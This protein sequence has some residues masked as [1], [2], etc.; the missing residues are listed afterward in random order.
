MKSTAFTGVLSALSL[1]AKAI[2][3]ARGD[4]LSDYDHAGST[5]CSDEDF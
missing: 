1:A 5:F 2:A 4:K 3:Q